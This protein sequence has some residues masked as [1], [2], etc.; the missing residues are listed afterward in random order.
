MVA[1]GSQAGENAIFEAGSRLY[2]RVLRQRGVEFA[3]ERI[4][5]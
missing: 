5:F 3:I 4:V 1:L 2:R